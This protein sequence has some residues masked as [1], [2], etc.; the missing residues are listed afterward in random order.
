[1]NNTYLTKTV[2]D[3]ANTLLK[4]CEILV[5][6]KILNSKDIKDILTAIREKE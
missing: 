2:K 6:K 3:N 1:M 5:E 4:L